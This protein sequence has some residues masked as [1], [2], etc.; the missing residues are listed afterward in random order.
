MRLQRKRQL[1][2][3]R[4]AE[5]LDLGRGEVEDGVVYAERILREKEKQGQGCSRLQCSQAGKSP[6]DSPS[7]PES[8]LAWSITFTCGPQI[9]QKIVVRF[10]SSALTMTRLANKSN[11]W[12]N[13][14]MWRLPVS[15]EQ[16]QPAEDAQPASWARE[17]T[18]TLSL[19]LS[20]SLL[21]RAIPNQWLPGRLPYI[22]T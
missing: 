1:F 15:D 6:D 13:S 10:S 14:R 17:I 12:K 11:C 3:A 18:H 16:Q 2:I 19:S 5:H 8:V 20:L 7:T 4:V 21:K 9:L 22:A